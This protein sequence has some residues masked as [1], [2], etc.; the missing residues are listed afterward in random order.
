MTSIVKQQV[1]AHPSGPGLVMLDCE[2]AV[3]RIVFNRPEAL[4]ALDLP[5]A[6]AFVAACEKVAADKGI[7]AVVICGEGRAFGVGGDLAALRDGG[8]AA[9]DELIGYMHR[10]VTLLAALDAPVIAAVHGA[11]SGGSL[12]LA[13]ACDLVLAAEGSR[14]NLAYANV[15]AS[16]DVA[17]SWS[18]PRLVGLRK[19]VEIALLSETFDAAEALRLGLVNRVVAADQLQEQ[20]LAL[21]QRLASGPTL[22]L[23][24]MKRLM[25][26][27]FDHDF[28]TQL[29]AERQGFSD[30][31]GTADFQEALGAFFGK[32]KTVFS[33][34]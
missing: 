18:L 26:S 32:R 27:S 15:A 34:R 19:A 5:T 13:L 12:S 1:V 4:N 30:S 31:V 8:R 25:R 3:A 16:C 11:V 28:S 24:R 23:G 7:R 6:A 9:A 21:A 17:G 22:A 14:F 33:G 10:G 20:A 2:G 29:D